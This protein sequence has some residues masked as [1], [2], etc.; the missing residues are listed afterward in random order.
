MSTLLITLLL[1][2]ILCVQVVQGLKCYTCTTT[3]NDKDKRCI[4]NPNAVEVNPIT[5]CNKKYCTTTR[6]EYIDPKDKVQS[7][8]RD[9]VDKP[10]YNNQILEDSTYRVYYTSC[11]TDLCNA[12]TG[13]DISVGSGMIHED[14]EAVVL[15]VPG[16]GRENTASS[17][18]LS[19]YSLFLVNIPLLL[20][21]Y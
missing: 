8:N 1:S 4:T 10:I 7:M 21:Y 18:D 20:Y 11:R 15:Y 3:E 19:I 12:G 14:G 13:K 9:C 2:N 5:N 6:V 17:I 16:I